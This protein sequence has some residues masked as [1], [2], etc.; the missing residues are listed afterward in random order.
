MRISYGMLNEDGR[1]A[2]SRLGRGPSRGL[3]LDSQASWP[4]GEVGSGTRALGGSHTSS[5]SADAVVSQTP[6]VIRAL[7]GSLGL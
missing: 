7:E 3:R 5:T 2:G 6:L 1:W 4:S